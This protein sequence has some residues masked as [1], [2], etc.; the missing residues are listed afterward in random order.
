MIEDPA[1]TVTVRQAEP[2]DAEAITRVH[3]IAWQQAYRGIVPGAY[4]AAMDP[5]DPAR[6]QRRRDQLASQWRVTPSVEFVAADESGEILGFVTV[7]RYR[8]EKHPLDDG[9][10]QI[11]AIYVNPERWHRGVGAT[12][13][14]T[15]VE[16]LHRHGFD[17]IRLW[18]LTD[19]SAARRFYERHG[20]RLD[21]CRGT[22]TINQPGQ[23]PVELHEL[24]YAL[25]TDLDLGSRLGTG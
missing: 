21:G 19:N 14:S 9:S 15:A 8:D 25:R 3:V 11:H 2:G 6:I 1:P 17:P 24:R 4:L 23:L 5:R 7:G 20:F 10:G 13:L 16:A 22:F 12:L 18:V